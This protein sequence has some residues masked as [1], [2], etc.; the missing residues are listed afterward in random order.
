[1]SEDSMSLFKPNFVKRDFETHV[2][3]APVS[4]KAFTVRKFDTLSLKAIFTKFSF[5]SV[6]KHGLTY[7]S[8][9]DEGTPLT[10]SGEKSYGLV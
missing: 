1:M 10:L 3:F 6:E 5:S 9:L 7:L 2:I 8:G 4:N